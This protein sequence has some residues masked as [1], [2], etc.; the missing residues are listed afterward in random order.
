MQWFTVSC[1]TKDGDVPMMIKSLHGCS[2]GPLPQQLISQSG[3]VILLIKVNS[4]FAYLSLGK[5]QE[6]GQS[7]KS[8]KLIK[9]LLLIVCSSVVWPLSRPG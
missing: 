3:A 5:A 9:S 7:K 2:I 4:V 8:I 1:G 6:I